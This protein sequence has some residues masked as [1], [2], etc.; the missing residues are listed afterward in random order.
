MN[1]CRSNRAMLVVLPACAG[2]GAVSHGRATK[3]GG[4]RLLVVLVK[5][6]TRITTAGRLALMAVLAAMQFQACAP[7][8]RFP[9]GIIIRSKS[10]TH[11][12]AD[13][14]GLRADEMPA[15]SGIPALFT[16]YFSGLGAT[17]EKLRALAQLRF[18]NLACVVFTDAPLVTDRGI[19][20]LSQ[21]PTLARLGLRRMAI[22][23]AACETMALRMRLT[24]VNMP[25]CTNVTVDGLLK[26]AQS[27]TMESLGFSAGHM[28]QDDLIRLIRTSGPKMNRMDIE[29]VRPAEDRLDIPALRQAGEAKGIT[30]CAVRNNLVTQL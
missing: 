17:D 6:L 15:L 24:D 9:A 5:A 13:I 21:I 3:A 8:P 20:H 30:L 11:V 29:M 7:E 12:H 4:R 1:Y 2:R 10:K 27:E 19:K 28:T 25:N 22:T 16:V 14:S 18:T 23:D 26:M